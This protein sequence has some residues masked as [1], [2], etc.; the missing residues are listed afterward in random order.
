[1]LHVQNYL[2]H[3]QDPKSL[4][5][6]FGIR[7]F[8]HPELP[9]LGLKYSQ[10]DS[11]KAHPIV[12]ECRGLVLEDDSWKLVAKPFTRF[13][14]LGENMEE[15]DRFDWNNFSAYDKEDGSL[16]IVYFYNGEWHV[17]TSGSFGLNNMSS[18]INFTWRDLFWRAA[19][20]TA[21][22]LNRHDFQDVTLICELC[23]PYNKI[24]RTYQQPQ[25]FLLSAYDTR[26][27][28][29]Y[30]CGEVDEMARILKV[31]RPQRQYFKDRLEIRDYLQERSEE[32]PTWEGFVLKDKNGLRFK[33]KTVPYLV[34]H[35]IK[36][37]GNVL[38]PKNLIPIVLANEQE[39]FKLTMPETSTAL[40]RT[41]EILDDAL[42]SMLELWETYKNEEYQ[43]NF[44]NRVKHHPLSSILFKVRKKN[45]KASPQE[46]LEEVRESAENR[47]ELKHMNLFLKKLFNGV[48]FD[49]DIIIEPEKT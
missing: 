37:N 40:D 31:Q 9:L 22:D 21:N 24:V 41:K 38:H 42:N 7:V 46:V 10:I 47:S 29:E 45:P 39:E 26:Y 36:D 3:N 12:R 13:F 5:D 15:F 44:A 18:T 48:Y 6:E 33:W 28:R 11:P 30:T 27:V 35:R 2:K 43:K 20:F 49:F 8:Q 32:D 16:T 19:P 17:N 23:S 25:I 1:M 34:R 4:T 14:N